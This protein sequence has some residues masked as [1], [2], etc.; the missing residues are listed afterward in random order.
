MQRVDALAA[1]E[2]DV[3]RLRDMPVATTQLPDVDYAKVAEAFGF[4]TASVHT[5][6]ELRALGP[7]L[8]APDGPVLI[9]CKI[10]RS[11]AAGFLEETAPKK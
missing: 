1:A 4:Q 8:A 6:E 3:L 7:L 5:V 11:V 2:P 10:N 9:D